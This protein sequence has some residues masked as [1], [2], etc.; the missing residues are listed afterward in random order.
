VCRI[1]VTL[2]KDIYHSSVQL[3][4][5]AWLGGPEI[6]EIDRETAGRCTKIQRFLSMREQAQD[7]MIMMAINRILKQC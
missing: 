1:I 3:S 4:S 2:A 5:S 7:H 6:L